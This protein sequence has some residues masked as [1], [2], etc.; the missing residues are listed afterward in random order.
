MRKS[1]S[2]FAVSAILC[3]NVLFAQE[4]DESGVCKLPGASGDTEKNG[5]LSPVGRNS[6]PKVI[7]C[8]SGA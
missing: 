1:P 7:V 3:V 8:G 5:V 4:C 2:V 6:I